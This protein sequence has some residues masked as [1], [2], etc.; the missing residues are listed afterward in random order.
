MGDTAAP[1]PSSLSCV[2][3]PP[4]M[5]N[6]PEGKL[7]FGSW[8]GCNQTRAVRKPGK[9]LGQ[10]DVGQQRVHLSRGE[11]AQIG[12]RLIG[13]RQVLPIPRYGGPSDRILPRIG[14]QP[15][16]RHPDCV[17]GRRCF[18]QGKPRSRR[19]CDQNTKYGCPNSPVAAIDCLDS[20]GRCADSTALRFAAQAF[21]IGSEI[22]GGLVS[23][24]RI[25]L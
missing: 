7:M 9:L 22:C 20:H 3:V 2:G 8:P 17:G 16:G 15:S 10:F 6:P 12:S 23:S 13:V 14:C 24:L 11:H 5:G 1:Q 21:Q 25:F 4:R 18:A 19:A